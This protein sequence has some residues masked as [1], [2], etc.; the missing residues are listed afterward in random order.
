MAVSAT[1]PSDTFRGI[2][3]RQRGKYGRKSADGHT[4]QQTDKQADGWTGRVVLGKN[5]II[6]GYYLL[7]TRAPHAL[8]TNPKK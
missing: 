8:H 4:N 7:P 6:I 5:G 3:G 1:S 2:Y